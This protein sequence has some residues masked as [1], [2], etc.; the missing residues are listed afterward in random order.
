VSA[1]V[2]GD[3]K[4]DMVHQELEPSQLAEDD[5]R[6]RIA[7]YCLKDANLPVRLINKKLYVFRY[8]EMARITGV[9]FD[10]LLERGQQIKV[11]SQILRHVYHQTFVAP[12]LH[13]DLSGEGDVAYEGATV[14]EPLRGFYKDVPIATLD[15]SSLYPSIMMACN[16]CYSTYV[17]GGVKEAQRRGL[18]G[19]LKFGERGMGFAQPGDDY[20]ISPFN[21]EV[22]VCQHI[23]KGVLPTIL[24][25][26]IK[27]R[28]SAQADMNKANAD[29][30][31]FMAAVFD[32]RQAAIKVSANSVYGFTGAKVGKLYLLAISATVTAFGRL[33]LLKV[34]EMIAEKYPGSRIIYGD[35]DSVMIEFNNAPQHV[36]DAI[37][38]LWHD[39]ENKPAFEVAMQWYLDTGVEGAAFASQIFPP[40]MKLAFEKV[41]FPYLLIN[42]KRYAG[43]LWEKATEYKKLDTKGVESGR[44][45]N[46]GFLRELMKGIFKEI[47][48]NADVEKACQMTQNSVEQ[49]WANDVDLS[50]L[51]ISKKLS[52]DPYIPIGF[53]GAYGSKQ[54]HVTV[55]NKMR[56]RDPSTAPVMGDRV[57]YVVTKGQKWQKVSELGEEPLHVLKSGMSIDPEY[58]VEKQLKTPLWRI[59][60]PIVG[61]Q[62]VNELFTGKHTLR[63][64]SN[65]SSVLKFHKEGENAGASHDNTLL[66]MVVDLNSCLKCRI[67]IKRDAKDQA[68]CSYCQ[69]HREPISV[70]SLKAVE[71]KQKQV[72]DM[73]V[74]C[75]NCR[76]QDEKLAK[77]C[78]SKECP[79]YFRREMNKIQLEDMSNVYKRLC[80]W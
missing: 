26:L 40:P 54:I 15:F 30:D 17:A 75:L 35:T 19:P 42:K 22:F 25:D 36:K 72:D 9:P 46:C 70:R 7:V 33:G 50:K 80:T 61:V 74:T 45:D 51:I 77:D 14:I 58:Y 34:K 73:W 38:K 20:I 59:L 24:E 63:R 27:A 8:V 44:R 11:V 23:R 71:T 6:K 41:Y 5:E 66:S 31:A 18:K 67:P 1:D 2:L 10:Y 28:K 76:K 60:A 79:R 47:F 49:L 56:D 13:P 64:S 16:L 3:M 32:G 62:R 65:L 37:G 55:A 21:N 4:E 78:H 43:L 39:P 48:V 57:P 12:S 53:P 68:L 52:C 29:L 69:T